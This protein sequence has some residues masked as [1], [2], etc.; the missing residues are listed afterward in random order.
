MRSLSLSIHVRLRGYE[1]DCEKYSE[2]A[3]CGWCVIRVTHGMVKSGRAWTLLEAA[4]ADGKEA[5]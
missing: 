1:N 3:I 2:A 5:A 4:F